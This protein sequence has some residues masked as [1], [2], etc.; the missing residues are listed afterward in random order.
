MS[1]KDLAVAV[2]QGKRQGNQQETK[3]FLA[4]KL[5]KPEQR[6][7][8]LKIV[9]PQ[10]QHDFCLAHKMFNNCRGNCP[11][12]LVNCLLTKVINSDG[13]IDKLRGLE[14]GR[15]VT[16]DMVID[17]WLETG[18]PAADIFDNPAWLICM[19]EYIFKD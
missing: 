19:A 6:A 18:E 14:I 3:S 4:G 10:W 13:D 5:R 17:E 1:I 8:K 2:L 7:G 12:S 11:H 15:G 9:I 16:T